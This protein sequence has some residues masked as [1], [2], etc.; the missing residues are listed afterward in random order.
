MNQEFTFHPACLLFP[1]MADDELRVLAEDIR[2]NGLVNAIVTLNGQILDGRNRYLACGMASVEPRFK[3]WEGPGSPTEWVISQNL[4]RRHLTS[5]QKAVVAFGL[6]P[7]LEAEAKE[8][9]RLSQGRG[10]KGG[11]KLPTLSANGKATEVAARIAKTNRVY[12]GTVKKIHRQAPE[13]VEEVRNGTLTVL[14]AAKI[15]VLPKPQRARAVKVFRTTER[16]RNPASVVR[17]VQMENRTAVVP[18][19]TKA[20]GGKV[21]IWCGDCVKLMGE[22]LQP[23]SVS[24]VVTSCPFNLGVR[25]DHYHDDRPEDEYLAWLGEVFQA[26]KRVLRDDGSFF[27]NVGSKR[28]V[29]WTAMKVAQV[30]GQFFV[31]QNEIIWVKAMTVEG[32]SYGH[33]APLNGHRYLNHNFESVFHFTKCGDVKLDRLAVGVPYQDQGN[34]LRNRATDNLRCGGDVW[35][36]PHDTLHER[37]EC[38]HPCV[39]PVELPERCIRLHGVRKDTLVLDPFCGVGTTLVAAARLGVAGVGMD[40]SPAY[41]AEARRR[42]ACSSDQ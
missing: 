2:Q 9:Q 23:G 17:Q 27:L 12:V 21:E 18:N 3:E 37:A 8:R 4:F 14:D 36:I 32:R 15:A 41:C 19:G 11:K 38:G 33:F 22:R 24:V 5:S 40:L 39:F 34:L 30:A 29:P 13:L 16:K 25:Y 6:L 20:A 1:Q 42:V 26:I 10:K 7:L 28:Q 35:F 31:L